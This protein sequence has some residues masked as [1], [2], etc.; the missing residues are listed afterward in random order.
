MAFDPIHPSIFM[1]LKNSDIR[2][3]LVDLVAQYE[4]IQSELDEAMA[5]VVRNGRF[6]G[7][8]HVNAFAKHFAD[9]CEAAHCVPCANGTDALEIALQALGIG[10][11]DEVIIPAFT[12]VATLEAVVNVGATPVLCDIDPLRYTIDVEQAKSL[13][14]S[15][16]K[17]IVPVHLFGQMADM[18]ALLELSNKHSIHVIE[19]AAQAHGAIY[20]NKRAGSI[21]VMNTFSFY[22]G[23]NLG[24]YGDAGAITT[25]D[26]TLF[27]KAKKIADHGRISKYD[28][29]IIGRNSRLDALQAAV[30]SVKLNHLE[31]W[32]HKRVALAAGY[33]RLLSGVEGIELPAD[34]EDSQHVYHLFVIRVKNGHREALREHLNQQGIETGI[35]YP[36]ALTKLK[37][38]T[39]QLKIVTSCEHAEQ[40]SAEVVSLPLY[41]ELTDQMQ[42]YICHHIIHFLKQ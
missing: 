35:H 30:L 24:A 21:G 37:V 1:D 23:K 20:K 16:T 42:D 14:T 39:D 6:I 41:P 28:H 31:A 4:S 9:F 34:F 27:I 17:A 36:I 2:I 10:K 29:E 40:A 18:D 3:P 15:K 38:T 8:D 11:G 22:P 25:N 7:G 12:F 5:S 32:N 13:I 26:E 19:D 33:R